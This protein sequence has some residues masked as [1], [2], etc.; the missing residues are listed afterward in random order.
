MKHCLARHVDL[1]WI[2]SGIEQVFDDPGVKIG[3]GGGKRL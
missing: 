3:Q 1:R 2:G